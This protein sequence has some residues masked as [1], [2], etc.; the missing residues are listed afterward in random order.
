MQPESWITFFLILVSEVLIDKYLQLEQL[1]QVVIFL[2]EL[3]ASDK[4]WVETEK[5]VGQQTL[6]YFGFIYRLTL[7][8]KFLKKEESCNYNF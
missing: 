4:W 6:L 7:K 2:S 8:H 3:S 5:Q 1:K